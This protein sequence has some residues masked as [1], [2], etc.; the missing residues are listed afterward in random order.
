MWASSVS[1]PTLM[2][3]TTEGNAVMV[4]F[5]V[6]VSLAVDR[7]RVVVPVILSSCD[8]SLYPRL[9][10]GRAGTVATGIT[11]LPARPDLCPSDLHALAARWSHLAYLPC[12]L[13]RPHV[14]PFQQSSPCL[15]PPSKPSSGLQPPS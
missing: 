15:A 5:L 1:L 12:G 6:Q 8:S 2:L 7:G 11:P 3:A 9:G 4:V 14:F 10:S 13:F